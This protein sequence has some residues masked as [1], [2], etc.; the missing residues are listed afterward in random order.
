MP[1]K[2]LSQHIKKQHLYDNLNLQQLMTLSKL[3]NEY[4]QILKSIIKKKTQKLFIKNYTL[5][6]NILSQPSIKNPLILNIIYKSYGNDSL[7]YDFLFN[8]LKSY[9]KS[10][11]QFNNI[12]LKLEF[13]FL[14]LENNHKSF[15]KFKNSKKITDF[16]SSLPQFP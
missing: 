11:N 16:Y 1:L 9:V 7:F 12:I 13:L 6:Y 10:Q 8:F 2:N 5:L 15:E 4:K 14:H 3:N